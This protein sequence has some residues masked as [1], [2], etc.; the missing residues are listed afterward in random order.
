VESNMKKYTLK[1][2]TKKINRLEKK[3]ESTPDAAFLTKQAIE[4]KMRK[5]LTIEQELKGYRKEKKQ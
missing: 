5:L 4:R 3:Y 1:R 2:V